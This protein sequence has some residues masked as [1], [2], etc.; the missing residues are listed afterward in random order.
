[1][2]ARQKMSYINGNLLSTILLVCRRV[3]VKCSNTLTLFYGYFSDDWSFEVLIKSRKSKQDAVIKTWTWF[4]VTGFYNGKDRNNF[5]DGVVSSMAS[6]CVVD[7]H[8]SSLG[9]EDSSGSS[10][11]SSTEEEERLRRLF[12]A[13][14]RDSDGLIDWW[15]MLCVFSYKPSLYFL[16]KLMLDLIVQA[17]SSFLW[18]SWVIPVWTYPAFKDNNF[19]ALVAWPYLGNSLG[20]N[21]PKWIRSC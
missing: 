19:F 20:S 10:E 21:L 12:L 18:Q 2:T 13:C 3:L 7:V 16:H 15:D 6:P 1:M 4:T 14:D 17:Y 5:V 8:D 9:M 11:S